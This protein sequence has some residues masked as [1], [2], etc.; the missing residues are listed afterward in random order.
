MYVCIY[1]QY[2]CIYVHGYIEY[3]TAHTYVSAIFIYYCITIVKY[4]E[5]CKGNKNKTETWNERRIVCDTVQTR[6]LKNLNLSF[7]YLST[8]SILY[9]CMIN[10]NI[11]DLLKNYTIRYVYKTETWNERRIACT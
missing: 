11:Y 2:L 8:C 5:Q 10:K 7:F 6:I 1:V 3:I 4:I 9:V